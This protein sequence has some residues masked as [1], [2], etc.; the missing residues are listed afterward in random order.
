MR[1]AVRTLL[2]RSQHVINEEQDRER[3]T[4]HTQGTFQANCYQEI[5]SDYENPTPNIRL[6]LQSDLLENTR[7]TPVGPPYEGGL[8]S[9]TRSQWMAG[10]R[11]RGIFTLDVR[12]HFWSEPG[13]SYMPTVPHLTLAMT[14]ELVPFADEGREMWLKFWKSE[15]WT[16]SL[17]YFVTH[18]KS[19]GHDWWH[20]KYHSEYSGP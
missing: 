4:A 11:S 1:S 16:L 9:L 19:S 2:H 6:E 20:R 5:W 12:G 17:D 10:E 14:P 18:T 3:N 7:W 15:K 13:R 8:R